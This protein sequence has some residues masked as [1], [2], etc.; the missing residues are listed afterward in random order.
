LRRET[1]DRIDATTG[2]DLMEVHATRHV[3]APPEKVW[4]LMTNLDGFAGVIAGI[5]SVERLDDGSGFGV[6]TTWRETRVMFGRT[7]TEDMWVT[8]IDPGHSY[9]V[10]AAS[11]GAEYRTT[12][13][14]EPVD[15][16]GSRLALSFS[17]RPVSALAKVMAATVGRLFESATRKAFEQDLVDIAAVAEAPDDADSPGA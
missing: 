11:H 5:E 12:Q 3:D 8:K 1:S 4:A 7:A 16:G 9:V 2:E 10:E 6:G 13:S 17:G 14:V 15:G